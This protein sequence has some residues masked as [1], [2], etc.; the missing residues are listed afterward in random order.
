M[1][2]NQALPSTDDKISALEALVTKLAHKVDN[3]VSHSAMRRADAAR[4]DEEEDEKAKK[5]AARDTLFGKRAAKHDDDDT[6]KDD[7]EPESKEW[8]EEES[9]EPEHKESKGDDDDDTH[10]DDDEGEPEPMASDDRRRDKKDAS[11]GD[12]KDEFPPKEKE[13]KE[14]EE[15]RGDRADARADA[16]IRALRSELRDLRRSIR[17]PRS[18]TDDEMNDL[19]ER[20]QE[21]DRV[22]QMHGLRASRPMDGERI[23]SYDRRMA[24]VF[25]KHSPKWKDSDLAAF[26][27]EAVTKIIAP[28]I[29]ADSAA[30]AYRVEPSEG[31]MLREVRKADRTGRIIS[32]F[33]GP[34]NAIN[35][36]LAP[37][38]MPSARVRRINTQP[39]Q[40]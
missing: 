25:Q 2:E 14:E 13:E 35:G 28:E 17:R 20:Q 9:E 8:K 19:A 40:F 6:H 3:M 1:P 7:A 10:K 11:R 32:E 37:F 16:Q 27:I 4:G 34:V 12:K 5:D 24:K 33:V 15:E 21:W 29:R 18:L 38:R 39:N 23:E 26:P 36:A 30:A 22:A 31:A